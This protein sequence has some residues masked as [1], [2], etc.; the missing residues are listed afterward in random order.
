MSAIKRK[1]DEMGIEI[2]AEVQSG[3]HY[4][5]CRIA[6]GLAFTAGQIPVKDGVKTGFGKVGKDY[7]TEEAYELA[8]LSG[9]M[10]LSRVK[11]A[12]IA[13]GEPEEDP[14]GRVKGLVKLTGFVNCV[15]TFTEQSKV[16]NGASDLMIEI[17]GDAGNHARSAVGVNVLP[18]NACV[19][20]EAVF[21]IADA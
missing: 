1:L 12:L 2:P 14:W 19:E 10:V 17:M 16:L 20:V 7:T 8:R 5:G 4:V 6:G 13:A 15:D 18:L 11:G 9:F 21:E 3:G